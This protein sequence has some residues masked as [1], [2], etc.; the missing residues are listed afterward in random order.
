MTQQTILLCAGQVLLDA[1]DHFRVRRVF[2]QRRHFIG[3]RLNQVLAISLF[4]VGERVVERHECA[5]A[6]DEVLER[7]AGGTDDRADHR[8]RCLAERKDAIFGVGDI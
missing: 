8:A 4:G 7:R 3:E 1:V 6:V 2:D 5:L